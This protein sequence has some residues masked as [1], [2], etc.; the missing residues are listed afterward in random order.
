MEMKLS[1]LAAALG[2]K[3]I[4]IAE[5]ERVREAQVK[6]LKDK[7]EFDSY[8][9]EAQANLDPRGREILSATLEEDKAAVDEMTATI[10]SKMG[11]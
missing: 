4:D 3:G 1:E 11:H 5:N 9:E 2:T 6:A 7:G 8:L 10:K